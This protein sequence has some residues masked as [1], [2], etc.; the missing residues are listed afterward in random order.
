[1]LL[2]KL[3]YKL[4][5]AYNLQVTKLVASTQQT[6]YQSRHPYHKKIDDM[7][8]WVRPKVDLPS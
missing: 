3:S 7:H 5:L 1:M 6:I 8:F 2:M 4:P